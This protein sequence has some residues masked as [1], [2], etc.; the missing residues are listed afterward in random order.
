MCPLLF[1]IASYMGKK[2]PNSAGITDLLL[3]L[4]FDTAEEL[5]FS[6]D[7]INESLPCPLASWS[8]SEVSCLPLCKRK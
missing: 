6:A 3:L 1:P 4:C 2:N 7:G 8:M 5:H